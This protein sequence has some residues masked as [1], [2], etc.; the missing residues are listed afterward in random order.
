MMMTWQN[1]NWI[2]MMRRMQVGMILEYLCISCIFHSLC[3]VCLTSPLHN[4]SKC[5]LLVIH[6]ATANLGDSLA[7]LT[8]FSSN[9]EDPYITLKDTV[10]TFIAPPVHI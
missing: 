1:M 5:V 8:V 4:I 10:S 2:N 9:E 6:L 7:G 3:C